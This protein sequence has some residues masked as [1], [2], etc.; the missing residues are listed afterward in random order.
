MN[1]PEDNIELELKLLA[2]DPAAMEALPGVL[3]EVWGEVRDLGEVEFHDRYLDTDDWRLYRAGFGCRLRSAGEGEMLTVKAV[4]DMQR[5]WASRAEFE[6]WLGSPAAEIP[7]PMPGGE[8]AER[9]SPALAGKPLEVKVELVKRHRAYEVAD[10]DVR[11]KATADL[12]RVGT[13]EFAEVEIELVEG[14]QAAFV[15]RAERM[16]DRLGLRPSD[17]DKY[18]RALEL[19]GVEPPS[20][21]DG[22]E[23]KLQPG[24]RLVDA[25]HKVMRVHFARLFWNEPG[26]RLGLDPEALHDMRVAS[27]RLIAALGVFRDALP[28]RRDESFE[29]GLKWL[30]K[31][32]GAARDMDIAVE[33]F[34]LEAEALPEPDRRA[35][36]PY[37]EHLLRERDKARA[38][39]LSTL[40]SKRYAHL[41]EQLRKFL[42]AGPPRRSS[43][44]KSAEP[45][46]EAA[47]RLLLPSV[48]KLRKKG[49]ALSPESPDEALHKYRR[50]CKRVRYMAE[51]FSDLYGKPALRLAKRIVA[52][53]DALGEHQDALVA[54]QTLAEFIH[55]RPSPRWATRELYVALG[56]VM[57]QRSRLAEVSR[58][59]FFKA[60]KTFD[61][62]KTVKP[63]KKRM[64]KAAPP[65]EEGTAE[66]V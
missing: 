20:L 44:P 23:T 28:A 52:M 40:D 66:G 41:V 55:R 11:G 39:M 31:N 38:R 8:I 24:D 18:A 59:D 13:H 32:L 63:I 3:E 2:A 16:R 54:S 62:K 57:E 10:G 12:V 17:K 58:K 27:R 34:D 37:R 5:G 25:A 45:V 53:Q 42:D 19:A 50:Q 61:R 21:P 51:F 56:R 22:P 29:R 65:P 36:Q 6:E 49:R 30:A 4:A 1:S 14:D 33:R 48:R 64:K 43:A 26:A 47:P 46:A 9:F 35:L 7:G 15:E 60:R